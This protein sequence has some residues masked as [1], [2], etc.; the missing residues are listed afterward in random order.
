MQKIA[1]NLEISCEAHCTHVDA[2]MT[3]LRRFHDDGIALISYEVRLIQLPTSTRMQQALL[4]ELS[5]SIQGSG[6]RMQQLAEAKNSKSIPYEGFC[7]P[8]ALYVSAPKAFCLALR[9]A[10]AVAHVPRN[11]WDQQP[12]SKLQKPFAGLGHSI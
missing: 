8:A 3:M 9:I 5:E 1:V 11:L 7:L 6:V 4:R 12:N 2:I 10:S